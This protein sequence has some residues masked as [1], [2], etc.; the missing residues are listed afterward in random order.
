VQTFEVTH[1]FHPLLGKRF[2]LVSRWKNWGGDRVLFEDGGRV[3]SLPTAWTSMAPPDPFVAV[4][5]G[6]SFFRV[7]DLVA[8]VELIARVD[9][10]PGQCKADSAAIV[11]ENTPVPSPSARPRSRSKRI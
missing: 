5:A 6:R 1:P 10:P 2:V 11:K 3:C 4:A 9:A 8:L 7:Q